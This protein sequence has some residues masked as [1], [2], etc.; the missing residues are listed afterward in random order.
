MKVFWGEVAVSLTILTKR[1]IVFHHMKKGIRK[2]KASRINLDSIFCVIQ[3]IMLLYSTGAFRGVRSQ[4]NWRGVDN[5]F[6]NLKNFFLKL[7]TKIQ[8]FRRL[9]GYSP[10]TSVIG[11]P[12]SISLFLNLVS[13]R[14]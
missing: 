6:E 1:R 4:K 13:N 10:I 3:V 12:L 7:S 5:F 9:G 14:R 11:T 2:G 8:N